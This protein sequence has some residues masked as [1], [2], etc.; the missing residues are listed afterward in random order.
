MYTWDT[1]RVDKI[2]DQEGVISTTEPTQG[3]YAILAKN[4]IL[5]KFGR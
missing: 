1:N 4:K 2:G 3:P 5:I